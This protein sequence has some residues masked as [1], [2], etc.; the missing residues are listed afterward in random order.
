MIK[1]AGDFLQRFSQLSQKSDTVKEKIT[2]VLFENNIK[3]IEKKD[4]LIKGGTLF[5]KI[6]QTKKAQIFLKKEKILG[7]FSQNPE[8]KHIKQIH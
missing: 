7:L 4:I 8:T 1:K 3:G 6:T 5:L 2:Q